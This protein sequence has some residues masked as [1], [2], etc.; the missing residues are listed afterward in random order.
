MIVDPYKNTV[1]ILQP[2]LYHH[3][4]FSLVRVIFGIDVLAGDGRLSIFLEALAD[5]YWKL[6]TGSVDLVLLQ[7][8]SSLRQTVTFLL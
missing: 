4:Q 8:A 5:W 3:Q 1:S 2:S 7:P 6:E